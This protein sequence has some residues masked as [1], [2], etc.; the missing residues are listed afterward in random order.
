M[1]QGRDLWLQGQITL[2]S[3]FLE[4]KADVTVFDHLVWERVH[5][6]EVL[7]IRKYSETGILFRVVNPSRKDLDDVELIFDYND[8]KLRAAQYKAARKLWRRVGRNMDLMNKL[9]LEKMKK[10]RRPVD[11]SDVDQVEAFAK[12]RRKETRERLDAH[13]VTYRD[14][15]KLLGGVKIHILQSGEA[16]LNAGEDFNKLYHVAQGRIEVSEIVD[17]A[18]STTDDRTA[19]SAEEADSIFGDADEEYKQNPDELEAKTWARHSLARQSRGVGAR[20][21]GAAED[22]ELE[23][24]DPRYDEAGEDVEAGYGKRRAA[25][26][27]DDD[28]EEYKDEESNYTS[29]S[30]SMSSSSMAASSMYGSVHRALD[31]PESVL[32]GTLRKDDIF[33]VVPFLLSRGEQVPKSGL[34]FTARDPITVVFSIDAEY[35]KREVLKPKKDVTAAFYKY[36]AVILGERTEAAEDAMFMRKVREK[37]LEVAR[38][39]EAL[40]AQRRQA[41]EEAAFTADG[42]GGDGET[43]FTSAMQHTLAVRRLFNLSAAEEIASEMKGSYTF[44]DV[45]DPKKRIIKAPGTFYVTTHFLA[46]AGKKFIDANHMEINRPVKDVMRHDEVISIRFEGKKGVLF[47]DIKLDRKM[48]EPKKPEERELFHRQVMS[49]WR[50][51]N[52]VT[53][54]EMRKLLRR[55]MTRLSLGYLN[56][57]ERLTQQ[58]I[59]GLMADM[60]EREKKQLFAGSVPIGLNRNQVVIGEHNFNDNL[61]LL[62]TG[63]VRVQRVQ[64]HAQNALDSG[65]AMNR[66][67][68]QEIH[69]GQIFGFD[70]FLTGA[71]A[72]SSVVVDSEKCVVRSCTK[73]QIM[74]RLR[75]DRKLSA[76]FYSVAA[77]SIAARL[78][79]LSP[80]DLFL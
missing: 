57:A 68:F 1:L 15:Q 74:A 8:R 9:R 27:D 52:E 26:D 33:G 63:I 66:V 25:S 5:Y 62:C 54:K 72:Y 23:Y 17:G 39:E 3:V 76:K 46:F 55:K 58:S 50:S 28:D 35:A 13:M 11:L 73:D 34:T 32:L 30:S 77:V 53:S 60:S 67:V 4:F 69:S 38:A 14:W 47:T 16:L 36:L 45:T 12:A 10:M 21:K 48:F 6:Q 31:A 59:E 61:F 2:E 79:E 78:S 51:E 80:L 20:G 64:E 65:R 24:E 40:L 41:E 19:A 70:S 37:R 22:P 71:P 49:K 56:Q 75:E 42:A 29:E 44:R 18:F 43:T 7:E